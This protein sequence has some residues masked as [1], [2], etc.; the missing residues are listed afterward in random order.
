MQ[1]KHIHH[2]CRIPNHHYLYRTL[3][4]V[5]KGSKNFTKY[6]YINLFVLLIRTM[7]TFGIL[8]A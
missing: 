2:W 8:Y 3:H 7:D 5:L 1:A 4:R 6:R